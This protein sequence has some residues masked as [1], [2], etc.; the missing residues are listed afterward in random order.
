MAHGILGWANGLMGHYALA[1]R[2]LAEMD[3]LG[4]RLGGQVLLADWFAAARA[5]IALSAGRYQDAARD[6]ERAVAIARRAG[7]IFAEGLAQRAWALAIGSGRGDVGDALE[8]LS[9]ALRLFEAGDCRV[10]LAQ[11]HLVW[12]LANPDDPRAVEHL[13]AAALEFERC[14][15]PSRARRAREHLRITSR[16]ARA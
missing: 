15:M 5:E 2:S 1:E 11:T 16:T 9:A 8:H 4:A 14:A 12:G 7:G 13:E 6:A 3:A 10:E